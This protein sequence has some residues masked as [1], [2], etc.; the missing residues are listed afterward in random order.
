LRELAP[1]VLT[2]QGY[3]V[4]VAASGVEALHAYEQANRK[5]DLL[6]TDMVMPGGIMG[7]DLA[8][9]LQKINPELKVIFTSGYSPGMAGQALSLIEGRNFLPKPYPIGK[10]AHLVREILDRPENAAEA[11]AGLTAARAAS[12][13]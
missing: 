6:L 10:L 13:A 9:R 4:L 8:E 11:D 7:E 2:A 1:L 5:I 12:Q 3:K